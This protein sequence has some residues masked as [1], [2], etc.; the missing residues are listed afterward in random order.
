MGR[1]EL[2]WPTIRPDWAELNGT[3]C[4]CL[5]GCRPGPSTARDVLQAGLGPF[6]I[7]LGQKLWAGPFSTGQICRHSPGPNLHCKKISLQPV[8]KVLN[9]HHTIGT[10]QFPPRLTQSPTR[11]LH[12]GGL[13]ETSQAPSIP[14]PSGDAGHTHPPLCIP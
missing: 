3:C 6:N 10:T 11:L 14:R 4:P 9:P 8:Y 1:A 12:H 2:K 13:N 5:M 7:V